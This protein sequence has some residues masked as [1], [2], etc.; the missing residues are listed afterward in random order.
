L[1]LMIRA[2]QKCTMSKGQTEYTPADIIIMKH[3]DAEKDIKKYMK[4]WKDLT[5]GELQWPEGGTFNERV[6]EKMKYRIECWNN[7]KRERQEKTE[8]KLQILK[9][10]KSRTK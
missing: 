8:K 3:Q 5:K 9:D 4:K 2:R 10:F 1:T 7:T 6:C